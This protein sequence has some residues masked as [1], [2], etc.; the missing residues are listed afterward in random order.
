MM[1][2]WLGQLNLVNRWVF[3]LWSSVQTLENYSVFNL[4]NDIPFFLSSLSNLDLDHHG[5]K[6]SPACFHTHYVSPK[7]TAK[8]RVQAVVMVPDFSVGSY[9]STNPDDVNIVFVA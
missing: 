6:K 9:E 8:H 1:F 4:P 5:L 2:G 7:Y 3:E